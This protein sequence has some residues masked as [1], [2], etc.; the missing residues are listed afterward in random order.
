MLVC[1]SSAALPVKTK[2]SFAIAAWRGK[3]VSPPVIWLKV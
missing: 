3:I 1:F 2:W